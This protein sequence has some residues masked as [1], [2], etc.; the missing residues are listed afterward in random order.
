VPHQEFG[1]TS[2]TFE[3]PAD[4][5]A[6]PAARRAAVAFAVASGADKATCDAV[7]IAVN[8]AVANAVTHAYRGECGRV[9]LDM[10]FESGELEVLVTDDG[11]GFTTAPSP[12]LGVGLVLMRAASSAFE[13]RDRPTGGVEVWMRF[14]I[15]GQ[16]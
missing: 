1:A 3:R 10:D 7:A 9:R 14:P 11:V 8:E 12:G 13:V 15:T 5:A 6:V 16:A 4:P 2:I